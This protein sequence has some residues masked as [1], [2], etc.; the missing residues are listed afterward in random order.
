MIQ[1]H[2][3]VVHCIINDPVIQS[4]PIR[5]YLKILR[6]VDKPQFCDARLWRVTGSGVHDSRSMKPRFRN[7]NLLITHVLDSCVKLL[8]VSRLH[9]SSAQGR[10]V[11]LSVEIATSRRRMIDIISKLGPP[12]V[13]QYGA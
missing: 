13:A 12:A 7:D 11:D 9:I 10:S 1:K 5:F 4:K 6:F 8:A 2:D 3:D